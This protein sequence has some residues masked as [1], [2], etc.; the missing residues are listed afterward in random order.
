[1]ALVLVSACGSDPDGGGANADA[2][3][4]GQAD[5]AA[6]AAADA[7]LADGQVNAGPD[8]GLDNP[9][10]WLDLDGVVNARDL[11]GYPSAGGLTVRYG[12]LLRGGEPKGL[13]AAGCATF[14]ALGIRTDVDLRLDDERTAS[15]APACVTAVADVEP[16]AM[17]KYLPPSEENY[18]R[19]MQDAEAAVVLLFQ[20]LAVADAAPFYVHCVIGRDRASYAAALV[21]LALGVDRASVMADF[22]LSNDAGIAVVAAHLEAVLDAIDGQGGIDAYLL[23]LG[24]A[25]ADLQALRAWALH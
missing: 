14:A 3:V 15:P 11:G 5:G 4:T 18:L 19:L 6:D 13:T 25:A 1:M 20:A 10:R 17:P 22:L 7:A 23:G 8:A 2:S 9:E 12:V 24:V 21:L 16:V